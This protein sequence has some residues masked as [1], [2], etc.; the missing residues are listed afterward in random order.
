MFLLYPVAL[1][2]PELFQWTMVLLW[3]LVALLFGWLLTPLSSPSLTTFLVLLLTAVTWLSCVLVTRIPKRVDGQSDQTRIRPSASREVRFSMTVTVCFVALLVGVDIIHSVNMIV[4]PTGFGPRWNGW[5]Y[6]RWSWTTDRSWKLRRIGESVLAYHEMNS[7]FP[8][9]GHR[10]STTPQH[11]GWATSLL[12]FMDEQTLYRSIRLDDPWNA[13]ANR[14]AMQTDVELFTRHPY[15]VERASHGTSDFGRIHFAGN[16]FL[17]GNDYRQRY[18]DIRD[19]TSNTILAGEIPTDLPPWGRPGNVR[20]TRLGINQSRSGFGTQYGNCAFLM[21]DGSVR[22]F[23][24]DTDPTVLR[25]L[26]NP[27]DGEKIDFG[28]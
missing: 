23:S 28:R 10:D 5:G 26:G 11:H 18:R 13:P 8:P 22:A 24:N 25:Q 1:F 7:E 4:R 21:A 27:R 3:T 12:P 2:I 15:R 17:V 9:G 19:G 6:A 16:Q 14:E 20:D